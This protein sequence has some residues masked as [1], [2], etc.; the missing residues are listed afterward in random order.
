MNAQRW[1]SAAAVIGVL[2]SGPVAPAQEKKDD[3]AGANSAM[4]GPIH[5]EMAKRAGEYT[6]VSKFSIPNGP[7][8]ETK[9]TAKITS[10]LGGRFL[11]EEFSG[12]MLGQPFTSIH[13]NGYNN[14][15]KQYEATWIYTGSTAMM[16]MTGAS[17]DGGKTI[18]FTATYVNEKG[19]KETL[20]ITHRQI[21][22]DHFVVEIVGRSPDGS[23]GATME[24]I[25]TRKK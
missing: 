4:P 18:K 22:E 6:A 7:T 8:Q 17:S 14:A 21:D 10:I 12:T 3:A 23:K 25:Y 1:M 24:T 20:D 15:T 16:T 9:G 11:Q 5:K 19:G 13:L 2:L